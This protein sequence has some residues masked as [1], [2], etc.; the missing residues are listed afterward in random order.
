MKILFKEIT[1]FSNINDILK[2][3]KRKIDVNSITKNTILDINNNKDKYL[4]NN[5]KNVN[6]NSYRLKNFKKS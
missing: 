5:Y 1:T 3:N 4:I 6:K 2:E